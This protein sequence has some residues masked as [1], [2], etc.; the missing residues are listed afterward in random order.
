MAAMLAAEAPGVLEFAAKKKKD[1][2]LEA[3]GWIKKMKVVIGLIG[4]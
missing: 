4:E 2:M 1:I 3:Y